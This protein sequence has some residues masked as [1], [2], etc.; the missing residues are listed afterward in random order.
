MSSGTIRVV[1]SIP[2]PRAD[3]LIAANLAKTISISDRAAARVVVEMN[4]FP[5]RPGVRLTLVRVM[6]LKTPGS[7]PGVLCKL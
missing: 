4:R 5:R 1:S 7:T 3:F 2:L 6:R